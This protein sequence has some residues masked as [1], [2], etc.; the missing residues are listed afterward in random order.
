VTPDDPGTQPPSPS[1][2]DPFP[3]STPTGDPS[4]GPSTDPESTATYRPRPER[5]PAG[6]RPPEPSYKGWVI[7]G[8]IALL[9]LAGF[10][11]WYLAFR[12]S[13]TETAADTVALSSSNVDFGDQDLGK[14]SAAQT[15]TL[16]NSGSTAVG[17][18]KIAIQGTDSKDFGIAKKATTCTTEAPLNA[19]ESCTVSVRF[20]PKARGDRT[21]SL[22]VSFDAGA[23]P[24]AV[25][26][27]GTGT[28][29]PAVVVETTRLDFGSVKLGKSE[30][31]KVSITN[32]GNAPLAFEGFAVQGAAA[33]S[34]TIT[35]KSTCS[36]EKKLKAGAACTISVTFKP[37]EVGQQD[38][39]L[40]V[41]HDA[42]GSPA[43]IELRGTGVGE[44]KVQLPSNSVDFGQVD[45]DTPSDPQTVTLRN[46]GT[47]QLS[48]QA[49]GISG[50]NQG[51]FTIGSDG[52][53]STEKKV[54]PGAT[55][56][57]E[58]VFQPSTAGDRSALLTIATNAKQSIHQ[59]Q[60]D[61]TGTGGQT[62]TTE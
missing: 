5:P 31:R 4:S 8:V 25:A 24:A 32:A 57:I 55:C 28:G 12:S 34:F 61:G 50:P 35:N 6:R 46:T 54:A 14:K 2:G 17:I 52:T 27:S 26:L 49:I 1:P 62:V 56:T 51:D 47:G 42:Q 36:T 33:D 37:A 18:A 19:D 15:I 39:M 53:C 60:I 11:I 7:A 41:K 23:A 16:T 21:A 40:V 58:L 9:A 13:S 22:V 3:P 20:K 30:A 29:N 38:A 44:P 45:V 48:L 10:L 59:V 43:Q